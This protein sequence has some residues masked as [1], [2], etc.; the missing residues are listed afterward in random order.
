VAASLPIEKR[1]CLLQRMMGFLR[2]HGNARPT[3]EQL[4]RALRTSLHELIQQ[5]DETS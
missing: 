4:E 1:E 5:V 2:F 3:D